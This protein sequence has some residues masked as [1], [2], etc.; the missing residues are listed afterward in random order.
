MVTL[1]RVVQKLSLNLAP[2]LLLNPVHSQ[3]V[4][5]FIWFLSKGLR[6]RVHGLAGGRRAHGGHFQPRGDRRRTWQ[7]AL[8][9]H[10]YN[11]I[12]LNCQKLNMSSFYLVRSPNVV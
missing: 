10:A 5:V 7:V 11:F 2:F 8:S 12:Q 9:M 4:N 1:Y 6:V 3:H